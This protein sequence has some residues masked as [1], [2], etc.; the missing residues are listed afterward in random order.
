MLLPVAE[1]LLK[2]FVPAYAAA[3]A[4]AAGLVLLLGPSSALARAALLLL[5]PLALEALLRALLASAY[6]RAYLYRVRP[7]LL[8]DHP[9]YGYSFRPSAATR[10]VPFPLY[11][12]YA[13]PAG[14][15][16][17]LDPERNRRERLSLRTN[18]LGF[19]GPEFSPA[20]PAGVTRIF[21]TGGST[22]A[23]H[24]IDDHET[25]PARLQQRLRARG[26]DVE[27]INGGVYG[28]DSYQEL[29]R[30]R[31]EVV[32][33]EPDVVLLHQGWNEE[34]NFSSLDLGRRYRPRVARG[35]YEKYFFYA[36]PSP[37]APRRLLTAV[38]LWKHFRREKLLGRAMAFTSPERW[39]TLKSKEYL[40]DWF[41]NVLEFARL[42][43]EKGI[44]LYMV[45]YPCLV[46]A[47]DAPAERA[48]YVAGSRLTKLHAHYQAF[49]KA[50]IEAFL[51]VLSRGIHVLDGAAPFR[52]LAPADKLALFS[53]ELHLSPQGEEL[54][55][56]AL[57]GQLAARP[58]LRAPAAGARPPRAAL[59]PGCD[60]ESLRA[61]RETIGTNSK[62][63]ANDIDLVRNS[64]LRGRVSAAGGELPSDRYTTY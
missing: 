33:Y 53:D 21:C 42:C 56:E 9:V 13:F 8:V 49:S 52:G 64:L 25:W 31:H 57:A 44:S 50:R 39:L 2:S 47:G 41:D 60:L 19:R 17:I 37:W 38:L 7:Y 16:V 22:T 4:L 32:R 6:G 1:A 29:L 28:W 15:G 30:F 51:G 55:A 35:Y 58:E 11:E 63:L 54:L 46:A 61:C 45:D 59:K 48:A 34:F 3:A 23:G 24:C 5:V 14:S 10:D 62:E 18:A 43:E 36:N 26:L 40:R 12:K 27:V 20:K